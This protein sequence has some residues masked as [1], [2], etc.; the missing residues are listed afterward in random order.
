MKYKNI[1]FSDYCINT[2]ELEVVFQ[3]VKPIRLRNIYK[4]PALNF[5]T[6]TLGDAV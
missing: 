1:H 3:Y 5:Q 6:P 4:K 2:P